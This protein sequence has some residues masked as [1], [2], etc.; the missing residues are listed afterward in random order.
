[1][2]KPY[3]RYVI[4]TTI[5]REQFSDKELS[6]ELLNFKEITHT[7]DDK[8]SLDAM[9]FLTDGAILDFLMEGG[10]SYRQL[11]HR[12]RE[13]TS[14]IT[15]QG[16]VSSEIDMEH[17]YAV[18]TALLVTDQSIAVLDLVA[19]QLHD[20][21]SWHTMQL[22]ESPSKNITIIASSITEDMP[23]EYSDE[24][25]YWLHTRGLKKYGLPDLSL[26]GIPEDTVEFYTDV[27]SFLIDGLIFKTLSFSTE[28]NTDSFF[29]VPMKD[30]S[31][32]T[33]KGVLSGGDDDF[34]FNNVHLALELLP[35][36]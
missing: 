9:D 4:F 27:F 30:Q 20:I 13:A 11:I 32:L 18:I 1:M 5:S 6:N 29:E 10:E 19:I 24:R 8:P 7:F 17:F 3:I 23:D 15:I 35:N 34:D 16:T 25:I 2:L 22:S 14:T 28:M 36:E 31:S 33:F 21:K 26:D 12:A